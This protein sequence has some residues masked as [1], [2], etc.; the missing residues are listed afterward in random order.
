M[1]LVS[2]PQIQD[3]PTRF[4][5]YSKCPGP[6]KNPAHN[7]PHAIFSQRHGPCDQF[8]GEKVGPLEALENFLRGV[9]ALPDNVL[10]GVVFEKYA[11]AER[12]HL[13]LLVATWGLEVAK[14]RVL[15]QQEVL[16]HIEAVNILDGLEF[17][18]WLS[19]YTDQ[20]LEHLT[21]DVLFYRNQIPHAARETDREVMELSLMIER[22]KR[23]E[24]NIEFE[25][26]QDEARVAEDSVRF[27]KDLGIPNGEATVE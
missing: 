23:R 2:H 18:Y 21:E 5:L 3:L 14:R 19:L 17:C 25:D 16:Q 1:E 26:C 27:G 7:H 13:Q 9:N 4:P 12:S 8:T 24:L 15:S 22:A 6:W 11:S 20:G 10:C